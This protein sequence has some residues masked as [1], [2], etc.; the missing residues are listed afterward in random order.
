M[1][2]T[3]NIFFW[4]YLFLSPVWLWLLAIIPCIL[5]FR[6]FLKR[7]RFAYLKFSRNSN[8]LE[9][10]ESPYLK[11]IL[12]G[13]NVLFY[14]GLFFLILGLAK[15]YHPLSANE[16]D[17][18]Y[19]EG[20]DII[21]ALDISQSMKITDFLPDR[22]QAA[23]EVA[24]EFIDNRSQDKIGLVVYEGEAYT[25]CPA[26]KNHSFLKACLDKV[27]TGL[28][29]PGTAIGTGLGTAVTRL[30]SDSLASKVVIL[31]TDGESN[32]GELT[33]LAAAEL[34]KNKN[35]RVYTIGVGKDGFASMPVQT[36]FGQTTRNTYVS[37]DEKTL[38]KIAK[39]T[40]G[41]YFRATDKQSLRSIYKTIEKME[42]RKIVENS[43]EK[44]QPLNPLAFILF[45]LLCV[46]IGWLTNYIVFR[47]IG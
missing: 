9:L 20:I 1:S 22:L 45:G 24:K 7:E 36:I 3:T 26:T 19:S 15:P 5:F 6:F 23:K 11:W 29:E 28:L 33:P 16:N 39:V 27:E 42:T 13:V 2:Q 17:Q 12:T 43:F 34:A 31:L 14:L 35:V 41:A 46:C 8:E 25:A 40:D 32:R 21:I 30:R 18:E 47:K 4:E 37:I 10:L 38:K 44:E